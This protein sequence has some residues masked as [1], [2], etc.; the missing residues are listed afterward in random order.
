VLHEL[1]APVGLHGDLVSVV[2]EGDHR[3]VVP[4]D[5]RQDQLHPVVLGG[6]RVDQCAAL[7]HGQ[8]RLERLDHRGVDADGPVGQPLHHPDRLRQQLRLVG[9]R[10]THVHVEDVRTALDLGDDVALDRGQVA[11]AQ[12][13]LEDPAAGGV[14]PLSDQ[15]EPPAVPDDDLG[16]R[17]AQR[18][19]EGLHGLDHL[20]AAHADTSDRRLFSRSLARLTVAEASGA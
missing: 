2:R 13:L 14:D 5:Q 1:Q 12:L 7:V 20:C 16:A 19:L 9:E 4:L 17:R 6:D 11:L 3:G 10:D 8:A 18:G 15:A